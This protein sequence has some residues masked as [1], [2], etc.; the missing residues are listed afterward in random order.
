MK[1]TALA[2]V[3]GVLT[4]STAA[5]ANWY[6]EG[7]VGYSKVKT[8]GLAVK[9]INDSSFSPSVAV[10]Y[11]IN[12]W[13]FALDYTHYGK[14]DQSYT[15][16]EQDST[17]VGN[18]ELNVYGFG[19][20][21]YYD[22]NLQSAIKPYVG[23]RVATNYV[24]L[25]GSSVERTSTGISRTSDSDSATKL[26]YGAVVGATYN[27]APKWDLNA[28]LEYNHLGKVEDVKINQYGAKVGVRYSF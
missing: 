26:G 18:E 16:I 17:T 15:Y 7:D 27:F 23:A 11:K 20:A 14:A 5:S 8:S 10:G 13:R 19:V 25:E 3:L 22:F 6:V 2:I 1:K 28:A 24:K 21:A 9:E 4:F 12:D